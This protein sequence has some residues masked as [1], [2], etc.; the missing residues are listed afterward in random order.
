MALPGWSVTTMAPEPWWTRDPEDWIARRICKYAELR[1]ENGRRPWLL[2]GR[3]V[4]H[5]PDH[6]PLVVDLSGVAWVGPGALDEAVRR[7][8][9]RF[10]VGND[11]RGH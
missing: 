10:D 2:T 9:Q 7:Y 4:G 1:D 3:T 11:S 6:E 8:R 5:G